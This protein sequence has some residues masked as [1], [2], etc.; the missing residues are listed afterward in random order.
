MAIRGSRRKCPKLC[1]RKLLPS[2]RSRVMRTASRWFAGVSFACAAALSAPSAFGADAGVQYRVLPPGE[3]SCDSWIRGR[4]VAGR[5]NTVLLNPNGVARADREGWVEGYFSALNAELLPDDRGV[6]RDVTAGLERQA[7][8]ARID[9]YCAANPLHA[10]VDAVRVVAGELTRDWHNAN[11]PRVA[12]PPPPPPAPP[13][14]E[15]PVADVEPVEATPPP[16]PPAPPAEIP[17]AELEP[18]AEVEPPPPPPTQQESPAPVAAPDPAPPQ[19]L[20]QIRPNIP[21]ASEDVSEPAAPIAPE[22]PAETAPAPEPA[23]DLAFETEPATSSRP[24]PV[25]Q[26]PA[27]SPPPPTHAAPALPPAPPLSAPPSPPSNPPARPT[28][29]ADSGAFAVQIGAYRSVPLAQ[30]AWQEFLAQYSDIVADYAYDIQAVDLGARG[31]W[32]RLRIGPFA[33]E[34]SADRVCTQITLSG[35]ECFTTPP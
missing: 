24:A 28:G 34:D 5:D 33:D 3:I 8:M 32:H 23:L 27:S 14:A 30:E 13:P 9:L 6:R 7:L 25:W 1:T 31:I 20:P 16:A 11:P 22:P 12:P 10:L 18:V 17:V 2:D 29:A 4:D 15:V 19:E 35:A 21:P 26:R